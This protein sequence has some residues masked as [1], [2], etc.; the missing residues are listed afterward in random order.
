MDNLTYDAVNLTPIN[1][2][3]GETYSKLSRT[4][5]FQTSNLQ[6]PRDYQS[7]H[8]IGEENDVTSSDLKEVKLELNAYRVKVASLKKTVAVSMVLLIVILLLISLVSIALSIVTF[9][10]SSLSGNKLKSLNQVNYNIL[11]VLTQLATTQSNITHDVDGKIN[12]FIN[13]VQIHIENLQI[14]VYCGPGQWYRVAYLNMSNDVEQCPSVWR[15][16]NDSGV[17]ACGRPES[18]KGSCPAAFYTTNSWYNRVCGR[19]IGYQYASTDAFGMHGDHSIILDGIIITHGVVTERT[20]IWSYVATL[21]EGSESP[22]A[23]CPCNDPPS[24]IGD[25]Y[26]CESGNPNNNFMRGHLYVNDKLWD[27]LQCENN[28][29]TG[30]QS[31]PWFSVRLPAPTIDSIE[32]R[33]CC[34]QPTDDEDTPIELLEL[35]VQ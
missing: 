35:Y 3:D 27:G 34:D 30:S 31:P 24:F 9:N 25:N 21:R 29:C 22:P 4:R 6:T 16:Y 8:I 33:I 20:H 26:Y 11:S 23:N 13:Q 2:D 7:Q 15:Q 28:C 12:N 5:Q 1:D 32:V 14:Q 19:V 17:R 10:R 18:D